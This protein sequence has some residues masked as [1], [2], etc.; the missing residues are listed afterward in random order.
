[1]AVFWGVAPYGLVDIDRSSKRVYS[2]L[3]GGL[4]GFQLLVEPLGEAEMISITENKFNVLILNLYHTI[5]PE[6]FCSHMPDSSRPR[7]KYL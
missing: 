7:T 2:P 5:V 4:V 3:L 1:M 6:T